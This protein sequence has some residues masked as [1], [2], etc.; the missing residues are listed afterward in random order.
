MTGIKRSVTKAALVVSAA[1][2]SAIGP[3]SQLNAFAYDFADGEVIIKATGATASEGTL[4]TTNFTWTIAG[5]EVTL[6]TA[7][8]VPVVNGDGGEKIISYKSGIG[9]LKG[10]LSLW[11]YDGGFCSKYE[12]VIDAPSAQWNTPLACYDG[13]GSSEITV[14]DDTN[15]PGNVDTFI[16]TVRPKTVPQFFS[17]PRR[18]RPLRLRVRIHRG[19]KSKDGAQPCRHGRKNAF[20][21]HALLQPHSVGVGLRDTMP[22]E[23]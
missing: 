4:G 5:E 22:A 6:G 16:L 7:S 20:L 3:C 9:D 23:G 8:G 10:G 13:N 18:N 19:R 2:I 1:V 12:A 11:N 14:A 21:R 15:F 17:V